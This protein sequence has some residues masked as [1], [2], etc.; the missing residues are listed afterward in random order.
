MFRHLCAALM[1]IS[2]LAPASA[3]EI[4]FSGY[5]WLVRSSAGQLGGPGP[6]VFSGTPDFVKIDDEGKLHLFIRKIGTNWACS[7]VF[8]TQAL[9]YGTYEIEVETNPSIMDRQAVFGFFTYSSSAEQ[10]HREL[11]VELSYWGRP[12]ERQNGQFVVQPSSL[13]DSTSRFDVNHSRTIYKIH[14]TPGVAR[15]TAIDAHGPV[16]HHWVKTKNVPEAGDAKLGLNLWLAKGMAPANGWPVEFVISRF[17][18]TPES[19]SKRKQSMPAPPTKI[20][21][22]W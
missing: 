14:W 22:W 20:H 5:Q 4:E 9:G 1:L 2:I 12:A 13:P 17:T 6:N 18:F 10:S 21:R 8:L 15:F 3:R 7:E 11:D 19:D 16:I